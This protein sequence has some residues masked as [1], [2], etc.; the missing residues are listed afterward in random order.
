MIPYEP[1]LY[2]PSLISGWSHW[3]LENFGTQNFKNLEYISLDKEIFFPFKFG[4]L[5][6]LLR[7]KFLKAQNR[8]IGA[9]VAYGMRNLFDKVIISIYK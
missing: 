7:H 6:D 8:L 1:S 4:I 5:T 9:W 2:E 3:Q